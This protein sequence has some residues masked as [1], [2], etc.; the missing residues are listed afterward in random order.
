MS[1]NEPTCLRNLNLTK[2]PARAP[3]LAL[4]RAD[5]QCSPLERLIPRSSGKS[6][7]AESQAACKICWEPQNYAR[8][9]TI[10]LERR[11]NFQV[12]W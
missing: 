9:P 5:Q 1:K 10:P 11:E 7:L 12:A 3:K 8:A 4:E 6:Q 2:R